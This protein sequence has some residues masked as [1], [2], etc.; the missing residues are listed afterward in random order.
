MNMMSD[1]FGNVT[2]TSNFSV[3]DGRSMLAEYSALLTKANQNDLFITLFVD[4]PG[5]TAMGEKRMFNIS[6]MDQN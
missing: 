1:E 5:R 6:M 3:D 4:E 2:K